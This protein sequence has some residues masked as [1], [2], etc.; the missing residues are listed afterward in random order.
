LSEVPADNEVKA[1]ALLVQLVLELG[2]LDRSKSAEVTEST[3]VSI[4]GSEIELRF[5]YLGGRSWY[6]WDGTPLGLEQVIRTAAGSFAQ[7]LEMER[8]MVG[9]TPW[10]RPVSPDS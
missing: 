6:E 7:T 2:R 1:R 5:D 3:R 8:K 10:D 4:R 9:P